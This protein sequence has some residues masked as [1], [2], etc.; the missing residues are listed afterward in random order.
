[1]YLI[2]RNSP[3]GPHS[4]TYTA[5]IYSLLFSIFIYVLFHRKTKN[6]FHNNYSYYIFLLY[7]P[8]IK[9]TFYIYIFLQIPK[10]CNALRNK[11]SVL[12][13]KRLQIILCLVMCINNVVIG[14][15]CYRILK[16]MMG[17]Q[18]LRNIFIQ[19]D[20]IFRK[21]F[22]MKVVITIYNRK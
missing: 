1:M 15:C 3:N 6:D 14:N 16:N 11:S 5:Y 7:S 10:I 2:Y 22:C 19:S 21:I 20:A 4:D 8:T 18:Y 13:K 17:V 9:F 12:I